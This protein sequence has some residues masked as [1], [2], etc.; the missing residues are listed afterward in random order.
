MGRIR[1]SK[2]KRNSRTLLNIDKT[3]FKADF[4]HNKKVL[5]ELADIPTKHLRNVIA[6][7]IVKTLKKENS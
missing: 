7:Y 4:E 1:T 5:G 3:R 2:I 6:G